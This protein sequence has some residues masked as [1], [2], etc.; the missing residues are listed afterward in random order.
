MKTKVCL[1]TFT[2]ILAGCTTMESNEPQFD[3]DK[4]YCPVVI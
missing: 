4:I 3:I 1:L 2:F